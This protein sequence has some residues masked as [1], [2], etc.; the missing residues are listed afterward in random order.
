[1]LQSWTLGDKLVLV[2]NPNYWGTKAKHQ[3]AD[4]PADRRQRGTPAGAPDRRDPGLRPR[5]AAGHPDDQERQQPQA[6]LAARRSTSATSA[7]T[8][9]ITPM[10]NLAVRQ[11]VAYGLDRAE[12][13]QGVLRGSRRRG[14]GVPAA[15]PR[16]ATRTTRA[17]ST[18][19]TR[20]RR[21]RSSRQ[22]GFKLP[23]HDR[24]LVSDERLAPV[25]AG[26]A[27]KNFQAFAASLEKS[28]LQGRAARG[29]VAPDYLGAVQAGKAQVYLLGWTG[30]FGDP[31]DFVGVF[32]GRRR[33]QWG[34]NNPAIFNILTKA[35]DETN[36]AKRIALYQQAQQHAD[37]VP[38][39]R[40]V[41]PHAARRSR[42]RR[43]S[44]ATCRARSTFSLLEP[45]RSASRY[46]VC[47]AG[48]RRPHRMQ[49]A[50]ERN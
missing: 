9:R 40:A 17:R 49:P 18:R 29:A 47:G 12:C 3:H 21:R 20:R 19:T 23:V 43:T 22:A 45:C 50:D 36:L 1:M 38:A 39:G 14:E 42:S 15:E 33:T 13:G 35:R 44:R 31:D 2:R 16:S 46:C 8:S 11:A 26:P 5:R 10:D 32:F 6:A 28:G 34:F 30:D 24:L 48:V 7:S 25:H 4:L 41:R 27:A 37:E